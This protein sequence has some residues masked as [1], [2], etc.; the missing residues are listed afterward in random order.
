MTL[1]T[2]QL[3]LWCLVLLLSVIVA[4]LAR[5]IGVLHERIA[6][7]G[8]LALGQGPQPGQA[9]PQVV[10]RTLDGA[11]LTVGAPRAGDALQLILFVATTCPVCK[12]LIPTA[13]NFAQTE[14]IDLLFVGD[15]DSAEY[16]KMAARFSIDERRFVNSADV[17]MTYR[18]GKLPYAVLLAPTG[19][20][21]AQGLVNTREHLESLLG[22]H[23]TGFAS[24]Q[25]Y[26]QSQ[27]SSQPSPLEKVAAD[28][29]SPH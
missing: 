29:R 24:I 17:G 15:G 1:L 13:Q 8:A 12:A 21:I 25:D 5:Q 20:I 2:S 22:V 4:A 9:A 18:V 14:S 10:G 7:V 16:R 26:L 23:E 28:G 3:L 19:I 11:I 27:K 6:P